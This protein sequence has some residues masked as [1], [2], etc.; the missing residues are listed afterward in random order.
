[1]SSEQ[2]TGTGTFGRRILIVHGLVAC[3]ALLACGDDSVSAVP[4]PREGGPGDPLSDGG[5][6][7]DGGN[8]GSVA[9]DV[10][11]AV[12]PAPVLVAGNGSTYSLEASLPAGVV[13]GGVFAVD[14]SGTPLPAGMSL[15]PAGV[16]GVGTAAVG[17]T[18]G[19]IFSYTEPAA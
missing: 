17:T 16:L 2:T 12:L 1:M 19:V 8:D 6:A 4:T 13:R 9:Q 14:P 15:S 7:E 11:W 10:V 18:E 5:L 3:A